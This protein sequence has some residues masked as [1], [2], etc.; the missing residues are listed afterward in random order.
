MK[1]IVI[2][3]LGYVGLSMAVLLAQ[4]NEVIALDIIKEKVDL[5]NNRKSPILDKYIIEYLK[6]PEI[7]IDS[8]IDDKGVFEFADFIIIA[9]PTNYDSDT[10]SFD[11]SSIEVVINRIIDSGSKATIVI[12]ST[13]PIGFTDKMARD[14]K[15]N[16]LLFSPE[17][18]REGK[19]LED[20]LYPSRIIVGLTN[21]S[22]DL[23]EKAVLFGN[24]LNEA[25]INKAR[26][27][28][29]K[30]TE[31]EAVKLFANTYLAARVAF[32]NELD[33]YAEMKGLDARSIIHGM[34]MDPRIGDFYNNPSFGY[35]GYCL[36]KDSKQLKA[37]FLGIPN[38][39]IN[40]TVEANT[41]RS[42]YVANRVLE[43]A[44]TRNPNPVI[45][46]YRLI[47]KADSDN[48]RSSAV[49][50]IINVLIKNKVSIIIY[51]PTLEK[52][53]FHGLPIENNYDEFVQKSTIVIAN[54]RDELLNKMD[55]SK[56]YSRDI[57]GNN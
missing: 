50:N 28:L 35:G 52:K 26:V 21:D 6:K 5:I 57:Y 27:I 18:L 34:C 10:N 42:V 12:K 56:I 2:V 39:I 1:K 3:G 43:L 44:M 7:R 4:H 30:S 51:E 19:A 33:T 13:I 55:S 20:N 8:R 14:Y 49:E 11:I 47:M 37:E 9:T 16:N 32:F 54:R 17:F 22:L 40:A 53:D 29:M 36:P 45:G 31:A 25:A 38:N 15:M 48:Y 46:I 41:T 23:H 24:I